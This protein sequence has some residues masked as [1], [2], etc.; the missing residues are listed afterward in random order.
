MGDFFKR[1]RVFLCGMSVC[2]LAHAQAK[3]E[4]LQQ[5]TF[6]SESYPPANFLQDN[7]PKGYAVEILHQAAKM[8]GDSIENEQIVIQ[9]WP[10]SYRAAL[11]K[12]NAVLFSTTRTEHREHLFHWV[13]P[14][15]GIKVVVLAR[16]DADIKIAEPMD[17]ANYRIGVIRDDIGEQMLLELGLPREAMQEANYVTQLAELLTKKRIDLLAYDESAALWFTSQAGLEPKLFKT[18][19]I[20]K[21]G[22]LYFA[23]NKN[24]PN[25]LVEKLQRGLDQLKVQHNQQGVSLYEEII[26][27]YLSAPR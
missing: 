18:V 9:P 10:R 3:V 5:L 17:M 26:N 14:I 4:S 2:F 8:V 27:R 22:E 6:Y 15:A 24:V 7:T 19:Y 23:F 16:V 21:E 1:W 20:L 25:N 11:T 12:E 13:G